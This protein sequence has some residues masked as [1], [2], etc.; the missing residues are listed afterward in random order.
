[1]MSTTTETVYSISEYGSSMPS[2]PA[3][4]IAA[5]TKALKLIPAKHRASAYLSWE[6]DYESSNITVSLSYTRQKTEDELAEEAKA[7]EAYRARAKQ[8]EVDRLARAM[9]SLGFKA[10]EM[11]DER[12]IRFTPADKPS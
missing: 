9:L 2:N 5:L 1:M 3:E 6:S 11:L 12:T 8:D 7:T 4:F 10:V